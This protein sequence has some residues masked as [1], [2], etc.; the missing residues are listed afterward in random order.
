MHAFRKH[1]KSWIWQAY[2]S[3]QIHTLLSLCSDDEDYLSCVSPLYIGCMQVVTVGLEQRDLMRHTRK[4]AVRQRLSGLR[5]S[6]R[7]FALRAPMVFAP[8]RC[9]ARPAFS[10]SLLRGRTSSVSSS[11]TGSIGSRLP[12]SD[13]FSVQATHQRRCSGLVGVFELRLPAHGRWVS[14]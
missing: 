14:P 11:F 3:L 4:S 7:A 1:T 5:Q 6:L 10:P 8:V 12:A 2:F 9:A 13:L